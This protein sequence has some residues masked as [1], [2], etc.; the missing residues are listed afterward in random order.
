[1]VHYYWAIVYKGG[2]KHQ[3]RLAHCITG[4]LL[5]L[6]CTVFYELVPERTL[7]ILRYHQGQEITKASLRPSI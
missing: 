6:H 2:L 7:Y 5:Y 1:M 4:P 3:A